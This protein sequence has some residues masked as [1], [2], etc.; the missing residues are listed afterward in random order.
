ML[1]FMLCYVKVTLKDIV[2]I[3]FWFA[4]EGDFA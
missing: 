2:N 3:Q 4:L 1:G